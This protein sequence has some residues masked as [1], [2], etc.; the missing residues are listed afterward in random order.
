[1]R[2]DTKEVVDTYALRWEEP[3]MGTSEEQLFGKR[4]HENRR[5]YRNVPPG[6]MKRHRRTHRPLYA[7]QPE[8]EGQARVPSSRL[9]HDAGGAKDVRCRVHLRSRGHRQEHDDNYCIGAPRRFG[10]GGHGVS[11]VEGDQAG[12]GETH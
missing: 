7:E 3:E 2:D 8:E 6:L 4:A 11:R 12:M 10:G 5:F 9:V 1:M